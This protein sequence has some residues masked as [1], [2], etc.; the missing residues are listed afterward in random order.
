MGTTE[1]WD[2]AES[3]LLEGRWADAAASYGALADEDADPRAQEGLAQVGWWLDDPELALGAREAAYRSFRSAGDDRGAA[4]AAAALGYDSMLFGRGV[5]VGRG[6]L[7]RA[8]DLLGPRDDVP[9]AGWLAVRQAEV[10]LNVDHD[11]AA[12][13]AA[14]TRAEEVGRVLGDGALRIV[15]SALMG[16]ARVRA[17]D[18][19]GGVPLLDAAVAAA[20]AGDVDDLMWMGKICCWLIN[21]CQ[22]THDL[23]RAADWCARVEDICARRDLAPLFAVCRTQYAS[24]LMARG[25]SQEAESTLVD[26]LDRLR[27]SRRMS[28]LDAVA[29]LGELRRRQGRIG[30]AEDLLRQAGYLAPAVT[31]LAQLHLDRGDAERAWSTIAELLRAIPV[32][33]V[34]ERV[35]ALAVAVAAGVAAGHRAEAEQAAVELGDTA[36]RVATP[37]FRAHAEA[38]RARLAEGQDAIR[39]W[40]DAARGFHAAGLDFDEADSR[41]GLA[42]ALRSSGDGPGAHEQETS[43]Q[44]LLSVARAQVGEGHEHG[45]TPRQAEVLR[46]LARGLSNPE[47]ATALHLSEHTVHRHVA[48]IYTTL[49]LGSRAA[50]AAYA[51]RHGLS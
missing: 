35:D 41:V 33:Q 3:A 2:A 24:I 51:V 27:G 48:N 22:E 39:C 21:A 18:V 43:A 9:E 20:T 31:S 32:D 23:G 34:L 42:G 7:S 13:L 26:V 36:A 1:D 19:D 38:A 10:A 4:R 8:A 47:I 15:G 37:A 14:A 50:A 44:V 16:L 28:R 5:A 17:G 29:Q 11:A 25:R 45:L 30:E 6:W 49:G 40:Q 12:A 46:L